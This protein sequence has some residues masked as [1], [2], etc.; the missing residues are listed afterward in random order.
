M[1]GFP[2]E[3]NELVRLASQTGDLKMEAPGG[4]VRF[5]QLRC[6]LWHGLKLWLPE[7]VQDLGGVAFMGPS[8]W[9]CFFFASLATSDVHGHQQYESRSGEL[10]LYVVTQSFMSVMVHPIYR[11]LFLGNSVKRTL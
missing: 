10:V 8:H 2:L 11:V 9:L 3:S 7:Q 5:R 6:L 4:S 1:L